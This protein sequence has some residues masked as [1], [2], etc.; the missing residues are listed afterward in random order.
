LSLQ[1]HRIP[2]IE[3]Q[4]PVIRKI[5]IIKKYQQI[6]A[7]EI[8]C[9]IKIIII[10][11]QYQWEIREIKVFE[12]SNDDFRLCANL[13]TEMKKA[14]LLKILPSPTV[15]GKETKQKTIIQ[16]W[17]SKQ[18]NKP[19]KQIPRQSPGQSIAEVV[20]DDDEDE[21]NDDQL[22]LQTVSKLETKRPSVLSEIQ[23]K[24]TAACSDG[25]NLS[26][27]ELLKASETMGTESGKAGLDCWMTAGQDEDDLNDIEL[28]KASETFDTGQKN[29]T[30]T[31]VVTCGINEEDVSNQ[32]T[33]SIER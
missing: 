24:Q 33:G 17:S 4:F 3:L 1:R 5:F 21:N 27:L 16:L 30:D 31:G 11:C 22:L 9:A 26:D 23:N 8:F 32:D 29:S 10:I 19:S 12:L 2:I 13:E 7:I 28:L 25:L 20:L 18:S 15:V 6:I 14:A